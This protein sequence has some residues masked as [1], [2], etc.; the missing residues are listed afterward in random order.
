M[1]TD[2]RREYMRAYYAANKERLA[3]M[4]KKSGRTDAARNAEARYKEKKQVLAEIEKIQFGVSP[5]DKPEI[6][7]EVSQP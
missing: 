3:Q 6:G 5:F 1:T 2:T 7:G 4:R